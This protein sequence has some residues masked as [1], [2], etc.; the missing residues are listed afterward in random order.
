ML[1]TRLKQVM[2]GVLGVDPDSLDE[3]ASVET[4]EAWDSLHHMNL[5]LA[6]ED[7]FR[8]RVPDDEIA[9]LTSLPALRAALEHLTG[10]IPAA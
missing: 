6:I 2:G 4:L 3:T 1:D 5:V 10:D 8:V 7:E 9:N